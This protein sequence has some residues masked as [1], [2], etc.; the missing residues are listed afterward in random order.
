MTNL[1]QLRWMYFSSYLDEVRANGF[2]YDNPDFPD[3]YHIHTSAIKDMVIEGDT[4]VITTRNSRYACPLEELSCE[5]GTQDDVRSFL[6]ENLSAYKEAISNLA[7]QRAVD[8]PTSMSDHE[9]TC[10]TPEALASIHASLASQDALP[11]N[12]YILCINRR[13]KPWAYFAGFFKK[14]TDGSI[15]LLQEKPLIH[16]GMFQDSV[17]CLKEGVY[18]IRYFPRQ[19]AIELYHSLYDMGEQAPSENPYF[20]CNVGTSHITV[21]ETDLPPMSCYKV[22]VRR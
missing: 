1:Y 20:I 10:L 6:L 13:L 16:L 17:L 19:G 21:D 5:E 22:P 14:Q 2:V 15:T 9:E 7:F 3:G 4:L 12:S 18:D 8:C 11:T